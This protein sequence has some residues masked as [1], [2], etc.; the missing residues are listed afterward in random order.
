M[1]F[2]SELYKNIDQFSDDELCK[3]IKYGY[4]TEEANY[5]AM[6]ILKKRGVDIPVGKIE[7]CDSLNEKYN[8]ASPAENHSLFA[9]IKKFA[10]EHPYWFMVICMLL[11][12]LI[13]K[14]GFYIKSCNGLHPC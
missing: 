8:Y 3:K 1:D 10:N 13:H 6:E 7:S 14:V 4:L 11:A 2:N 9:S 12:K 5:I